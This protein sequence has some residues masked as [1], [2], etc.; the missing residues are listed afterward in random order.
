MSGDSFAR[1]WTIIYI[2]NF[3]R[4]TFIPNDKGYMVSSVFAE[5]QWVDD[6]GDGD[7]DDDDDDDGI[8]LFI[9]LD[10]DQ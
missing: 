2:T 4:N 6:D 9:G 10:D 3:F 5:I 7:D 8:R 1:V